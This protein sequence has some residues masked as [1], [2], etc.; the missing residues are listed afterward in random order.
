MKFRHYTNICLSILFVTMLS[1]C[2][3]PCQQTVKVVDQNADE[4]VIKLYQF[5]M[6]SD[7]LGIM[8]GHEDTFAYGIG[9]K[10]DGE[11]YTSD[12][13]KICG[14]FPAVFGW[15]LGHIETGSPVNIDTV[16]FESMKK[17]IVKAHEMG[18]INTISWHPTHPLTGGSTW[19]T[20]VV[21]NQLLPGG[22]LNDKFNG[23]ISSIG[24]FFSDL[25]DSKG[26]SVPVIFRPFHEH[27]GS[28]FW[29][30]DGLCSVDEY[31]Q[32]WKYTVS[33]LRD[34]MSVH[35]VLYAYS[36]NIVGSKEEY[37]AKYPGNEWVDIMGVD[38]YDFPHY[39]INYAEVLPRNL[40]ILKSV[41]LE[42][43]KPY[44]LTETGYLNEKPA[45]WWTNSLLEFTKGSGIRWALIWINLEAA[46]YYFTFPGQPSTP[47]FKEFYNSE[48]TLFVSD[49]PE[50]Y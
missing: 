19:D 25:K 40:E 27:N 49:L 48:E 18:G 6:Q 46:Q 39:G 16:N 8:L 12:V 17:F 11:V 29:W 2:S 32:L 45:Q 47:D 1:A 13:Y 4:N 7:T 24:N 5:L 35:N 23:W 43:N 21:V 41:A 9:W 33:Y 10:H 28:W 14:D 26:Q 36:P 34:T 20:T 15:D 3:V 30:G 42:K 44:A 22:A 31:T 37:L 50:I 38:V